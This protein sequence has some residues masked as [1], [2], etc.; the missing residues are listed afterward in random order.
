MTLDIFAD[1]F[2]VEI[3]NGFDY[4]KGWYIDVAG[5]E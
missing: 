5:N 2:E 4:C 3:N 1:D